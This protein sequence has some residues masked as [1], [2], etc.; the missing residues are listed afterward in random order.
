MV[1]TDILLKNQAKVIVAEIEKGKDASFSPKLFNS[2][3]LR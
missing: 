2:W 1:I 3:L